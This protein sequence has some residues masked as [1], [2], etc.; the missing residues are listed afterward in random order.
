MP[1][2]ERAISQL[3]KLKIEGD[4]S[5]FERQRKNRHFEKIVKELTGG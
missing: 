2:G 4:Y 1:F 3:F 5:E